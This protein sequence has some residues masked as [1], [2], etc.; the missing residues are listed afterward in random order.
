[1]GALPE[2]QRITFFVRAAVGF[3]PV[4][5]LFPK[6]LEK[7]AAH[8]SKAFV[9]LIMRGMLAIWIFQS[10]RLTWPVSFSPNWRT[11]KLWLSPETTPRIERTGGHG[12]LKM[13]AP[14]AGHR[15]S[16]QED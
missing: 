5:K 2:R 9:L 6:E 7:I 15:A 16:Y 14:S 4:A 10:W 3:F 12:P 1:M 8:M 13:I 11:R